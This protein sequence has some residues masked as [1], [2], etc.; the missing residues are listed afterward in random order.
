MWEREQKAIA[1]TASGDDDLSGRRGTRGRD[2]RLRAQHTRTLKMVDGTDEGFRREF[3][4]QS[5]A[6]AEKLERAPRQKKH[7]GAVTPREI[8]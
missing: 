5:D 6:D 7:C 3:E 1:E 2:D 4:L 8:P